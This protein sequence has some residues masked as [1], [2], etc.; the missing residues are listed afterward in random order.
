[1]RRLGNVGVV[2]VMGAVSRFGMRVVYVVC[3][4]MHE[5]GCGARVLHR[6]TS[7]TWRASCTPWS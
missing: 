6:R 2:S 3:V 4:A 7:G 1:M 5:V